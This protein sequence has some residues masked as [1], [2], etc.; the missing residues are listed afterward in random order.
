LLVVK[1][2][3]TPEITHDSVTE[4]L[5][6]YVEGTLAPFNDETLG[7]ISDLAKIRKTYKIPQPPAKSVDNKAVSSHIQKEFE[8]PIIG[9]IALRGAT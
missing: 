3:T 9:A 7:S 1:V 4:H 2:S 6:Q 5:A 8:A